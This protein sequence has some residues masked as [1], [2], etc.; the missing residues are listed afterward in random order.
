MYK[1]IIYE[2]SFSPTYIGDFGWGN[3]AWNE[4]ML[5][6]TS[7]EGVQVSVN[8]TMEDSNLESIT[9]L[10]GDPEVI[11]FEPEIFTV[12]DIHDG[13]FSFTLN[14]L[15]AGQSTITVLAKYN[16]AP[17]INYYSSWIL[18]R[19]ADTDL[20]DAEIICSWDH[21]A[22]ANIIGEKV[23]YFDKREDKGINVTLTLDKKIPDFYYDEHSPDFNGFVT[24]NDDTYQEN[25]SPYT[26]LVD[27][28]FIVLHYGFGS[29]PG[30][31]IEWNFPELGFKESITLPSGEVRS[32]Q[33]Q[34]ETHKPYVK[35]N[36]SGNKITGLEWYFVDSSDKKISTPESIKSPQISIYLENES[37]INMNTADDSKTLD[38]PITQ[39]K[40]INIS[41]I[42]SELKYVWDFSYYGNDGNMMTF[43]WDDTGNK[44]LPLIMNVGSTKTL[45]LTPSQPL[46]SIDAVTGNNNI[47]KV[48]NKSAQNNSIS[49]TLKAFEA[50]QTN[51]TVAGHCWTS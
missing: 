43:T 24:R 25:I 9:L 46:V 51:I 33:T 50:G 45:T 41:F 38:C 30:D 31:K 13:N 7:K 20:S 1:G 22:F 39:L 34:V 5:A 29:A 36:T 2:W 40:N 11:S 14:A 15:K 48:S 23:F 42:E 3:L 35:V 21:E 19:V 49:V 12:N 26:E 44:Y 27:E 18:V 47:V 8:P 6:G 17:Y 16:G 28:G 32:N 37:P 4:V 10:A